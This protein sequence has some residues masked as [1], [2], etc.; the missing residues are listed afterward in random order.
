MCHAVAVP[1]SFQ[2]TCSLRRLDASICWLL[3]PTGQAELSLSV[4]MNWG[5]AIDSL[6]AIIIIM[7]LCPTRPTGLCYLSL[8][9]SKWGGWAP[10][11]AQR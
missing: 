8:K 6:A 7:F 1:L 11:G 2:T 4:A 9:Q 10:S 3:C 5:A